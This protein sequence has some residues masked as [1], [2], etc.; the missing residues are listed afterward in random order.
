MTRS[1]SLHILALTATLWVVLC[2]PTVTVAQGQDTPH[3]LTVATYNVENMLDTF[4]DPHSFDEAVPAKPRKKIKQVA[5]VIRQLNADVLALQEVENQ[6]V[7]RTMVREFL[8]DMGYR[9]I[10]V[11]PTNSRH[12]INM[13]VISR[14]PIVS[15]TSHR[16]LEL[17]VS[18][19][20]NPRRFAR[21]LLRVRMMPSNAHHKMLD[22]YIVHFKSKH[23]SENDPQ[24]AKWRLAEAAASKA[25]IHDALMA[26]LT[27]WVLLAGDFNDTPDSPTLLRLTH[28]AHSEQPT[29]VDLHAHL[30]PKQR[31]TYLRPPHR[32]TIDYILASPALVQ[33]V[34][35][36]SARVLTDIQSLDGSD[37]AP[38]AVTFDLSLPRP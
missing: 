1:R 24:S 3:P 35:P 10:A 33:R 19:L 9:Y 4:D 22:L 14:R 32:S 2:I 18:G 25:I 7:L 15:I 16:L 34:A 6:G 26:D 21:D 17:K 23:H 36:N 8:D 11:Q 5:A 28:H 38:I 20:P 12:G 13:A 31:I 29:L 27:A 37:H 30:P